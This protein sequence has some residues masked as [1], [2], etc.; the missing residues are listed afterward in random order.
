MSGFKDVIVKEEFVNSIINAST[1]A[2]ATEAGLE[3]IEESLT[4]GAFAGY[5]V[6]CEDISKQVAMVAGGGYIGLRL[7]RYFF[8]KK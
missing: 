6:A 5:W 2:E 3:I 4:V 7:A 1:E 8:T